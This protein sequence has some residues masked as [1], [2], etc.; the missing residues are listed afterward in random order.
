M[1]LFLDPSCPL[2]Y[3]ASHSTSLHQV[4]KVEFDLGLL[5]PGPYSMF[6][7]LVR[8]FLDPSCLLRYLASHSAG[9]QKVKKVKLEL[10]PP[11][12]P[13]RPGLVFR[14]LVR[15]FLDPSCPLRY[16]ASHSAS[17]HQVNKVEFDLGLLLPAHTR[18][19]GAWCAFS[20]T[21]AVC[22]ATSPPTAPAYKR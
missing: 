11:P 4:N 15:L 3:L 9:L 19:S 22:S 1:R 14:C 5:L 12:P 16:L 21:P 6:R 17:L 2:R 20:S 18:C 10:G 8:L 13:P 7:C